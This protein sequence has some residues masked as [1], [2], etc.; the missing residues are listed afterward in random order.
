MKKTSI[1]T[2]AMLA[3]AVLAVTAEPEAKLADG[4]AAKQLEKQVLGYWATDE[5]AMMK[6]LVE[7]KAMPK[8]DAQD[9]AGEFSKITFHVE[10]GTVH[11]YSKQGIV[12]T[13]YEILA[14]DKAAGSLTVRAVNPDAANKAQALELL[15]K[16][17]QITVAG[18][19]LPFILRKIDEAEFTQ[20]KNAVP[21]HPAGG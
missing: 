2:L 3:L 6:L 17:K 16:D 1:I 10:L 19:N 9:M 18:E 14:A 11:I 12:T 7:K 13:P 21:A 8:E 20:R 15:I 5:E 4:D